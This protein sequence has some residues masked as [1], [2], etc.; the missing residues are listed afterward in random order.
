M[1]EA[2]T[3][4]RSALARDAG[5]VDA[6]NNLGNVLAASGRREEAEQAYRRVLQLRPQHPAAPLNLGVLLVAMQRCADAV[7]LLRT[8]SALAPAAAP[9]RYAL[10]QAL[11]ATGDLAGAQEAFRSAVEV[12]A[13][14]VEARN[15]LGFLLTHA[16]RLHEAEAQLRQA[17]AAAPGF[18]PA[19]LNL[20]LVLRDLG[21]LDEAEAA[22]RHA[23]AA[24]PTDPA[25]R[26][27]LG[28]A[29]LAQGRYAEG[30]PWLEAR[31][32]AATGGRHA[33]LPTLPFPRW[34]GEPLAGRSVVLWP[35]QGFGDF[36]QFVRFARVLKEQ[37]ASRVTVVCRPALAQLAGN[38][39]GVD[40]VCTDAASLSAHDFWTMLMDVPGRLRMS[41]EE[42]PSRLP[43]VRAPPEKIAHWQAQLPAGRPK[44]A[45][46][47]RGAARQSNDAHRSL[48]SLAALQPL[49]RVPGVQFV[50]LQK[51][52]G[53]DEARQPPSGQ[54]LLDLGPRLRDWADT[55]AVLQQLDLVITVDTAVAH[56]AGAMGRPVWVLLPIRG[57]DWRWPRDGSDSPWYPGAMR[58]FRQVSQ[59]D[60]APVVQSAA[61]ALHE[62][63]GAARGR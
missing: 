27:Q 8:A 59:G 51:G 32:A 26:L 52:G 62:S 10:G 54:P 28:F 41:L 43:Y 31:T 4:F 12:D 11:L 20:G 40:A 30:W 37:G 60:W 24:D 33:Q 14:H 38:S 21:R 61:A 22:C 23:L 36:F 7:P 47:W 3:A 6:W 57:L 9:P 56:L 48:P 39:D 46:V 13:G 29:L 58:L 17:T 2:E 53:E 44:V 15:N 5:N 49:W 16:G 18:V 42:I 1:R 19:W 63:L 55:A 34:N 50:S 35:E 45:L 25:A